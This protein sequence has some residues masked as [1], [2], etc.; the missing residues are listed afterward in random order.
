[1]TIVSS[2]ALIHWRLWVK[3]KWCSSHIREAAVTACLLISPRDCGIA[4]T[5]WWRVSNSRLLPELARPLGHLIWTGSS[6]MLTLTDSGMRCCH[7]EDTTADHGLYNRNAVREGRV[8]VG[9]QSSGIVMRRWLSHKQSTTIFG[10]TATTVIWRHQQGR[11]SMD[12]PVLP[13][14][15]SNAPV[16]VGTS[17]A[18][19]WRAASE[20]R[21]C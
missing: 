6:W 9:E 12:F 4:R 3:L 19:R 7:T 1:M 17:S 10:Y 18:E 21:H 13:L 20:R 5:A 11:V 14:T 8:N 15:Y 16:G 2:E